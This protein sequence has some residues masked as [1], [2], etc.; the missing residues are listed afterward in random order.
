[1]TGEGGSKSKETFER[2]AVVNSKIER[3][4]SP[5]YTENTR[6][7]VKNSVTRRNSRKSERGEGGG[8]G[9]VNPSQKNAAS[10]V[11]EFING[12]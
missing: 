6:A 9:W 10:R 3:G 4:V 2:D 11:T 7:A 12:P 8:D 5:K 1:M